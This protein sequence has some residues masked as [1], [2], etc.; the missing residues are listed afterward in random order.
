MARKL[1][2]KLSRIQKVL[3][4]CLILLLV[5]SFDS[6]RNNR[7]LHRFEQSIAAQKHPVNTTH[8]R[9]VSDVG[10]LWG[11]GNQIEFF[12]GEVRSYNGPKS[13][14]RAF[15][16]TSKAWNPLSH[17]KEPL[18]VIFA[19]EISINQYNSNA[20]E[21][22]WL[23]EIDQ[24]H[25]FPNGEKKYYIIYKYTGCVGPGFDLRGY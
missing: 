18:K 19:D 21:V 3:I 12:A 8:F 13:Q 6:L 1:S 9:F 4:F 25:L 24:W 2:K 14:I 15:Y 5:L 23:N 10:N 16:A 20:Y 11:Q 17:K 7:T 22:S